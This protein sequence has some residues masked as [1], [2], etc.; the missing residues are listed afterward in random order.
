[1]VT[2]RANVSYKEVLSSNYTLLVAVVCS[3]LPTDTTSNL[4][5]IVIVQYYSLLLPSSVSNSLNRKWLKNNI[6]RQIKIT[7]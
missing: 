2:N 3:F 4:K 6:L 7:I 1:M 5:K